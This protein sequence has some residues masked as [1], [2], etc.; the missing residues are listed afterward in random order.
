MGVLHHHYS[1]R[2]SQNVVTISFV[3]LFPALVNSIE[4]S[5]IPAR[6]QEGN[7]KEFVP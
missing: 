6:V 3:F 2:K 1:W 7:E 5:Q 4:V